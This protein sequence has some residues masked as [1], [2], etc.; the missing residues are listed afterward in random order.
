MAL[1]YAFGETKVC[2]LNP[3]LSWRMRF[4]EYILAIRFSE[5]SHFHTY[6]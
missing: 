1:L 3:P 2:Q 5:G 4:D 6:K